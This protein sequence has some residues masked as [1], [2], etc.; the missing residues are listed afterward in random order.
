MRARST[1]CI[2]IFEKEYKVENLN[3]EDID[4]IKVDY[5]K[6]AANLYIWNEYNE[7]PN[8]PEKFKIKL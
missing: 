4:S 6:D 3:F 7:N 1:V 5:E 8:K 2:G